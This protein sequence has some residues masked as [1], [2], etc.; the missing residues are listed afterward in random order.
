[1]SMN[2]QSAHN[3]AARADLETLSVLIQDEETLKSVSPSGWNLLH[4]A[5]QH[6]HERA[7]SEKLLFMV[8]NPCKFDS[9]VSYLISAGSDREAKDH[10]GYTALHVAVRHGLLPIVQHLLTYDVQVDSK[11]FLGESAGHLALLYGKLDVLDILL[12][13]GI[14]VEARDNNGDS[15]LHYSIRYP[16]S[17]VYIVMNKLA[18]RGAHLQA[19]NNKGY[20][21]LHVAAEVGNLEAIQALISYGCDIDIRDNEGGSWLFLLHRDHY[22]KV[23]SP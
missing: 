19:R 5:A 18:S 15:M 16:G 4:V 22:S 13:H 3:A 20:S 2:A 17:H 6:D 11:T 21:A 7:F 9:I 14:N 23:E 10:F 12:Q 1:M 8:K